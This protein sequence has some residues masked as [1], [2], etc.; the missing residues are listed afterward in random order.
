[1]KREEDLLPWKIEGGHWKKE[2]KKK[3]SEFSPEI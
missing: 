1:M 3:N 2:M